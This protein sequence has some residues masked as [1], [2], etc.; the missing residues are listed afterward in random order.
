MCE[1]R[2][3]PGRAQEPCR[4]PERG[5]GP[6]EPLPHPERSLTAANGAG[7]AGAAAHPA[8]PRSGRADS[9]RQA[10]AWPASDPGRARPRARQARRLTGAGQFG[11]WVP[12]GR[13]G[14]EAVA[15]GSRGD[16]RIRQGMARRNLRHLSWG[17]GGR[18]D[19]RDGL[20]DGLHLDSRHIA[21]GG[22]RRVQRRVMRPQHAQQEQRQGDAGAGSCGPSTRSRNSARATPAPME[23]PRNRGSCRQ[24]TGAASTMR[25]TSRCSAPWAAARAVMRRPPRRP[26]PRCRLP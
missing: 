12:S 1:Y 14:A 7:Q 23:A 9:G 10:S 26:R 17:H 15:V 2:R 16:C 3:P 5:S 4:E 22:R 11:S 20:A 8:F 21:Q 25:W 24:A 19:A 18:G 13:E 6:P